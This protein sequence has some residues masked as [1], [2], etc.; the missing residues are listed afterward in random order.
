[1][2]KTIQTRKG[3]YRYKFVP[4]YE[5]VKLIDKTIANENLKLLKQVCDR[6]GLTFLLYFG[7]LL[8]AVREHDFITHDEDIDL[9]MS[10]EQMPSFLDMLFQLREVGFELARFE[11][12]GFL[13]IIRKGEYIDIYFYQPYPSDPQLNYC[14]MDV[15]EKKYNEDVAPITFLGN[16]YMAPADYRGYLEHQY[17]PDW[18]TPVK[19]YNYE[20]TKLDLLKQYAR[21]YVKALL[22]HTITERIQARKDRPNLEKYVRR[23]EEKRKQKAEKK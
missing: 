16:T 21:Q 1:M 2:H 12:R 18:Q 22:P 7:T 19:F 5:G 4:I 9:I 14:C 8:G 11:Y 17:G 6:N 20:R 3:K 10:K 13:S 15:W 23:I